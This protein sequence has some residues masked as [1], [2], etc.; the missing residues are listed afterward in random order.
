LQGAVDAVDA[1]DV[2]ETGAGAAEGVEIEVVGVE[3]HG[4]GAAAEAVEFE[5]EAFGLEGAAEGAHKLVAAAG[6]RRCEFVED[7]DV[8]GAAAEPAH[9]AASVSSQR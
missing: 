7:G 9:P 6:G 3:E 4:A 5:A 2:G 1:A 8:R